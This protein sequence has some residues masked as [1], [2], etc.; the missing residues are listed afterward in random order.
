MED[1]TD[2][3]LTAQQCA[4]LVS[5]VIGR[6]FTVGAWR[7]VTHRK[8]KTNP[9]PDPAARQ[10]GGRGRPRSLWRTSQVFHWAQHRPGAGGGVAAPDLSP[11]YWNAQQ[12]ADRIGISPAAW[13]VAAANKTKTNP[14]PDPVPADELARE[15]RAWKYWRPEE[16]DAWLVRRPGRITTTELEARLPPGYWTARQCA[17]EAGVSATTWTK[18]YRNDPLAPQPIDRIGR[19]QLWSAD[20]VCAYLRGR[21][22]PRLV[23][24]ARR[25][26]V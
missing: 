4:A 18:W 11:Q 2:P 8:T 25:R 15:Y 5:Q 24:G 14:A 21:L 22:G 19:H 12:C 13:W 16:V 9:A 26:S 17:R 7:S 1:D 10:L 3:L 20:A 6:E 23:R